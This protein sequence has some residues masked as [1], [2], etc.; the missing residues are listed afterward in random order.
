MIIRA[1][2]VHTIA[3]VELTPEGPCRVSWKSGRSQLFAF[4]SEMFERS[5]IT[6]AELMAWAGHNGHGG[7]TPESSKRAT[8]RLK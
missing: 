1:P 3:W 4:E 8:V 2:D 6:A 5:G 7:W